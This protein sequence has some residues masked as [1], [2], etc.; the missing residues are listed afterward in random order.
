MHDPST[1]AFEIKFPW[2]RRFHGELYR[3]PFIT[4]WHEDPETD[5]SDDSCGWFKR[6]RH[7]DQA[8]L[9]AFES[10][11]KFDWDADWGGY[12]GQDGKPRMSVAAIVLNAVQQAAWHHFGKSRRKRD[13]FLRKHLPAILFFAENPVD[14]MFNSVTGKHGIEKDRDRRIHEFAAIIYPW[15]VRQD[16]KWWQHARWH[17]WHW[18]FQIHPL[19]KLK[20]RLFTR[21]DHCGKKFGWNES[22]IG[23][24]GGSKLWHQSCYDTAHI[25]PLKC[26][27][28]E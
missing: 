17:F 19:Q 5:G 7:C 4:V 24:W 18:R 28:A 21:C 26:E 23:T 11:L 3:A 8:K 20:R 2:G 27:P 13:R 15:V 25:S 16:Q 1:V 12:F 22:P 9:K 14:S 6:A 10:D